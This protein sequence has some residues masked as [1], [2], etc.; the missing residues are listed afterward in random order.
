MEAQNVTIRVAGISGSLRKGS[1]TR[2]ALRIALEGAA[3]TGAETSLIDLGEYT[4]PFC[5]GG[6]E[7]DPPGVNRLREQIKSADGILL[8]SPT[9]HG[10][11]SGVLKNALDLMGFEQFEGK[12]LGLIS[13]SGGA[14][15]GDALNELRNIGRSLHSW[16]V[17]EQAMIT[18]AWRQFSSDGQLKDEALRKRL[19]ETG[20]QVGR[21]ARLHRCDQAGEFLRKWETAVENPGA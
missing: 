17:P 4:L 16:V 12:M 5:T 3:S 10:S 7:Q 18:E 6:D 13:V 15:G 21:F 8:A 14:L 9:Y 20:R 11:L 19:L 2:M 1:H